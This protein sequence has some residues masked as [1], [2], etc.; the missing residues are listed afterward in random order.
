MFGVMPG[1][2]EY[3]SALLANHGF[4]SLAL[5]YSG[6]DGLPKSIWS[7]EMEYFE[8]AINYLQKRDEIADELGLAIVGICKGGQIAFAMA[9][10]LPGINCVIAINA[11]PFAAHS[12]HQNKNRVWKGLFNESLQDKTVFT[13]SGRCIT[14]YAF[15]F[16]PK[17]PDHQA[18]LFDFHKRPNIS[19]MY[20]TGLDDDDVPSDYFANY[21]EYLL[22]SENHPNYQI[23]RYPGAGHLIEAPYNPHVKEA[24]F[25]SWDVILSYGGTALPHCHAQEDAWKKQLEF[26]RNNLCR[27]KTGR[28]KL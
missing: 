12:Y 25:R 5:P 24:Y 17:D 27:S 6:I 21:V 7:L 22:K 9:D 20:I 1:T 13:K 15:P 2:L 14:R 19:Y 4:A 16:N 8:K 26:L 11:A 18:S 3:K 28:S 10:C 23:L